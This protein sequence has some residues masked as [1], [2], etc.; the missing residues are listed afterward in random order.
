MWHEQWKK[1][2]T[3]ILV[4]TLTIPTTLVAGFATAPM[5]HASTGIV[6][7][8]IF[9]SPS[10]G[11]E[12]VEIYNGTAST[13]DIS[14]W[15]I[16]D[17][18]GTT[19]VIP[20]T[21]ASTNLVAHDFYS[22]DLG[23]TSI[24]NDS[25][26]SVTLK[27]AS[28]T[29]VD[30]LTYGSS[31]AA[32]I[33]QPGSNKSIGRVTD[34]SNSW[35]TGL[36]PSLGGSNATANPLLPALPLAAN[37]KAGIT[38][39]IN[40]V[41]AA[42]ENAVAV[43]VSVGASSNVGDVV[44]ARIHSETAFAFNTAVAAGG[45]QTVTVNNID[46]SN[47]AN[48]PQ[49]PLT[50]RTF[51]SNTSGISTAYVAGTAVTK[52]TLAPLGPTVTTPPNAGVATNATSF[53]VVGTV[54][55][56]NLVINAYVDTNN[57]GVADS[58]TPVATVNGSNGTT[59]G[60]FVPLTLNTMNH[61]VVTATDAAGNESISTVVP[62]ITQDSIAPSAPSFLSASTGSDGRVSISFAASA[63]SD[64][65]KYEVFSDNRTGTVN[66]T[67][68]I[69]TVTAPTTSVVTNVLANGTYRFVVRAVDMAGNV[70]QNT[71]VAMVTV[72]GPLRI[73]TDNPYFGNGLALQTNG[74]PSFTVLNDGS[75]IPAGSAPTGITFLG[76]YFEL[77][78][79]PAPSATNPVMV[80]FYYTAAQLA[81]AKV[82]ENQLQGVYFYDT[83]SKTWKL[84]SSTG[85]NTADV[86]G[87]D[88][89]QYAGYVWAN[90][91][92]FTPIAFGAKTMAPA[93]PT[94]VV[95]TADV[96]SLSVSWNAVTDATGYWVQYRVTGTSTF[97]KLFVSTTSTT[98]QGLRGGVQYDV[99][100]AA[101]DSVGNVSAFSTIMV[102][103]LAPISLAIATTSTDNSV[104]ATGKGASQTADSTPSA[105]NTTN[106]TPATSD[107]AGQVKASETSNT[108]Q[109]RLFVTL[110]ILVIAAGAGA[111][112][113]YGYQWWS[114]R[115]TPKPV[116]PAPTAAPKS[117]PTS[118][119]KKSG[120]KGSSKTKGGRW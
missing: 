78:A 102:R 109:N 12:Y 112:G 117:S 76:Q 17:A 46:V 56:P 62:T 29:L 119:G 6:I 120:S 80:K 59:F 67:T 60:I 35:Y 58:A 110:L 73:S 44:V 74:T 13:V 93:A 83:A 45:A 9:P 49:G 97:T 21:P 43:D 16:S 63:S 89:M 115:P 52:D 85:V 1:L 22:F 108:N 57:D 75:T 104:A 82:S 71:N 51:V 4:A 77:S 2:I 99:Q 34:G 37:V 106:T 105:T 30:S 10:A 54:T 14:N 72:N 88:G 38:N 103:P 79:T 39:P 55:E 118:N 5:A 27:N 111:A 116:A 61:F 32:S 15:S 87:P 64:V 100:V 98:I 48:F 94:N 96:N 113:Y 84:Y 31:L 92:H 8:E 28:T 7:N 65:S 36:A 40:T 50:L 95:A 24:L 42:T 101:V 86:T 69:A 3:K 107:N 33:A 81:A 18:S 53:E 47:S 23:A 91:D 20:V 26:D 41:N 70:D 19:A 25:G 68:P 66:Y 90:A 11:H 114:E